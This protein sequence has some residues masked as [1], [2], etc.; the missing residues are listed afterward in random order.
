[1]ICLNRP[2]MCHAL[3][4]RIGALRLNL[5][6]LPTGNIVHT[7]KGMR[8]THTTFALRKNDARPIGKKVDADL[9]DILKRL[10]DQREQGATGP[11]RGRWPLDPNQTRTEARR[12]YKPRP[13]GPRRRSWSATLQREIG[14]WQTAP[15]LRP[16]PC[17]GAALWTLLPTALSITAVQERLTSARKGGV[18]CHVRRLRSTDPRGP[19]T[20]SRADGRP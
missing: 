12:S 1:M 13:R 19:L 8:K 15:A 3:P 10:V 6:Q 9:V 5:G 14:G 20:R 18:E 16:Y 17:A 4:C 7:F 2:V 11:S